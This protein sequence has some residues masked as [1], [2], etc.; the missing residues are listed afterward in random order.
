MPRV[1]SRRARI[2][3]FCS[4]T[5][6]IAASQRATRGSVGNR[7][8]I[9]RPV[10][11]R[12]ALIDAA[13]KG[14]SPFEPIRHSFPT[15]LSDRLIEELV[16]PSTSPETGSTA[17]TA[18]GRCADCADEPVIS[19]HGLRHTFVA[20]AR[21]AGR[22]PGI[23]HAAGHADPRATM[24]YDHTDDDINRHPTYTLATHLR[25]RTGPARDG[26][27]DRAGRGLRSVH[28]KEHIRGSHAQLSLRTT[29]L[30]PQ[31]WSA[32]WTHSSPSRPSPIVVRGMERVLAGTARRA[33]RWIA[34]FRAPL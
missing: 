23:Q 7:S 29:S 17:T 19:P 34:P 30:R 8:I 32:R 18:P 2:G 15:G 20:A 21:T 16:G 25:T 26:G 5:F 4:W 31:R 14:R 6:A 28:S 3:A 24:R 12:R 1:A 13:T 22:P 9:I 11:C 10:S 33:W 27:P